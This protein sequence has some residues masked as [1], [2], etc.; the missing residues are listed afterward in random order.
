MKKTKKP[1]KRVRNMANEQANIWERLEITPEMLLNH[2]KITQILV[3]SLGSIEVAIEY[4]RGSDAKDARE[5][6]RL[7]DLGNKLEHKIIPF[8]G[9]CLSAKTTPKKMM[10]IIMEAV[11]DQS[12]I[13]TELLVASA[14]PA[15]VERTIRNA[16]RVDGHE[17][18]KIIHQNRGF[19][20]TPK[21]S[22]INNFGQITQDNR[23]QIANVAV[24]Q[25][26]E[27][28]DRISEAVDKFNAQRVLKA[29]TEPDI[30]DVLA[31]TE[32]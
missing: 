22:I 16:K 30:I 17:D 8:E 26:D 27:D 19:T 15:I 1:D 4:L 3:K 10:G 20:P 24:G 14:H 7:W 31:E 12:H 9:Y 6:V 25:L 32:D 28:N 23:K 11:T 18:R 2:P 13:A 5:L 29:G 21:N